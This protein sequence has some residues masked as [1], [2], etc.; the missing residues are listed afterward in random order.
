MRRAYSVGNA[1]YKDLPEGVLDFDLVTPHRDTYKTRLDPMGASFHSDARPW[2]DTHDTSTV[3]NVLGEMAEVV[4]QSPERFRVRVR[5]DMQKPDA[6]EAYRQHKEGFVKGCSIGF[7]PIVGH[8]HVEEPESGERC[9]Q[10]AGRGA[11]EGGDCVS[12]F[13]TGNADAVLVYDK[14]HVLEGSSCAAPSNPMAL[15]VRAIED[16]R[17]AKSERKAAESAHNH[18]K[19]HVPEQKQRSAGNGF[20]FESGIFPMMKPEHRGMYRYAIGDHMRMAGDHLDMMGATDHLELRKFHR[21]AAQASMT[22]ASNMCRMIMDSMAEGHEDA[23]ADAQMISSMMRSAPEGADAEIAAEWQAC[24]RAALPHAAQTWSDVGKRLAKSPAELRTAFAAMKTVESAHK[25]M[26]GEQRAAAAKTEDSDRQKLVLELAGSDVGLEP[27]LEAEM[28]GFDAVGYERGSAKNVRSAAPWT[29]EAIRTF[30]L[31]V[32]GAVAQVTRTAP[33]KTID[34][35][36]H[37]RAAEENTLQPGNPDRGAQL[38]G[39]LGALIDE[40]AKRTGA[41]PLKVRAAAQRSAQPNTA[42]VENSM[43]ARISEVH[44]KTR[45]A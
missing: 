28:L 35:A 4:E 44:A 26:L 8:T 40:L 2:M 25:R 18:P 21:D 19:Q 36:G 41:D 16:A 31:Q 22:R 15:C 27:A 39:P 13:G 33:L 37:V 14:Y 42:F 34:A 45:S 29:L 38:P 1:F 24:Q 23:P 10:C 17:A 20:A 3:K 7:D 9:A 6:A 11:V 30:K 32:Q 5:F 43:T 12:C